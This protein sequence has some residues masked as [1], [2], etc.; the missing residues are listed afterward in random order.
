MCR[1]DDFPPYDDLPDEHGPF[2]T[3]S[4]MIAARTKT[5]PEELEEIAKMRPLTE[6]EKDDLRDAIEF[7][8]L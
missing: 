2:P 8:L 7:D 1:P 3:E 4:Q 6:W 5:T